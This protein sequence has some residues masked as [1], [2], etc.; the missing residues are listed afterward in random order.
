MVFDDFKSFLLIVSPT[1]AEATRN[2]R[3]TYGG[4]TGDLRGTYGGTYGGPT[5]EPT[6]ITKITKNHQKPPKIS[7]NH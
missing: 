4:P 2:L 6:F 3:G 1:Y 5:G 7:K